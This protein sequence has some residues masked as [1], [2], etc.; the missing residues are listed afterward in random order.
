MLRLSADHRNASDLSRKTKQA[1]QSSLSV[2]DRV[3][4]CHRGTVHEGR[5]PRK[6]TRSSLKRL[7]RLRAL[8]SSKNCHFTEKRA[9]VSCAQN[10]LEVREAAA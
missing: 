5:F 2:R 8:W 7:S 6:R 10:F 9:A 3:W 1:P 4:L